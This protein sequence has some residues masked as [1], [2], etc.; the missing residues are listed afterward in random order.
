MSY[1]FGTSED[2]SVGLRRIATEQIE[3]VVDAVHADADIHEGVLEARKAFKRLRAL[4]SL[5][6]DGLD[7]ETFAE[8]DTR[9]RDLGRSLAA[10]RE[11]QALL[12][13]LDVLDA[14]FPERKTSVSTRLRASLEARRDGVET[15][16]VS[17]ASSPV[18]SDDTVSA[19]AGGLV[20][21]RER[22]DA[23]SLV[24]EDFDAIRGG[25][26]RHYRAARRGHAA[27]F[28]PDGEADSE[29]FHEWRKQLQ[30]HW[31]HMQLITHAWPD[32]VTQRAQL[33]HGLAKTIGQEHDLAMLD[34]YL[35]TSDGSF[36]SRAQL[37]ATRAKCRRLQ[38]ELRA[39]VRADGARLFLESPKAF[40]R[41]MERY[42]EA[43][44]GSGRSP[45][46][47]EP[48]KKA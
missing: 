33:T 24:R 43:A 8:L 25:L 5:F 30:R 4:L 40:G 20:D 39:S 38:G 37:A 1:R 2:F 11:I 23:L 10:T 48:A 14:R 7:Q 3:R 44:C 27:A 29:T 47:A 22:F 21:V 46:A 15:Q 18:L 16:P 31:R 35:S 19:L 9:L 32:Y 28:D 26:L 6:R 36:G 34:S 41:R 45:R 12:D 17:P 13:S 42:W